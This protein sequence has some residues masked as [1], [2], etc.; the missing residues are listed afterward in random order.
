MIKPG[1][2]EEKKDLFILYKKFDTNGDGEIDFDEF[3]NGFNNVK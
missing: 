2:E 3:V 1:D